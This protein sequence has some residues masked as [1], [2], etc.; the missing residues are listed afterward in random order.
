MSGA[1]NMTT[2]RKTEPSAF[3]LSFVGEYVQVIT[4]LQMLTEENPEK[5][6][7]LIVEGVIMDADESYIYMGSEAAGIKQAIKTDHVVFV[8][9]LEKADEVEEIF[10]SINKVKKRDMN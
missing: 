3:F 6:L 2:K 10:S 8:Q 9:V 5:A 7:P 1:D 4:A